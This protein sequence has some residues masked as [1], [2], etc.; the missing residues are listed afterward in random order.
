M[1]NDLAQAEQLLERV[2]VFANKFRAWN[3]DEW[4]H[5]K[6]NE[7]FSRIYALP[8][9]QRVPFERLY[10]HGRDIAVDYSDFLREFDRPERHPTFKSFVDS[11]EEAIVRTRERTLPVLDDARRMLRS[12]SLRNWSIEQMLA[13][14]DTELS[15]LV[16]L[17][18]WAYVAKESPL[19]RREAGQPVQ[20]PKSRIHELWDKY[21]PQ[22]IVSL[23][24]T[25]VGGVLVILLTR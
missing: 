5:L 4:P 16:A 1:R 8:P 13:L 7:D 24:V 21:A 18:E 23:F 25:V 12:L 19:Y 3:H 15:L 17:S 10:T 22:I 20:I 6:N 2:I 9:E 14:I 11:I